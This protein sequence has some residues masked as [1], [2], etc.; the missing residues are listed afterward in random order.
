MYMK[1]DK[2]IIQTRRQFCNSKEIE[3][4][5]YVSINRYNASIV[6]MNIISDISVL[7]YMEFEVKYMCHFTVH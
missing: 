7:Y 4:N 1:F 2:S 3:L 5:Q 6:V